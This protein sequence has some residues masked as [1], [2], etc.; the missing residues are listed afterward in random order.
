MTVQTG[1]LAPQGPQFEI[2]DLV[3]GLAILDH[4]S[5]EVSLCCAQGM[6]M[7]DLH[8][9]MERPC[10]K[11]PGLQSTCAWVKGTLITKAL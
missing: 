7:V 6:A 9:W 3:L 4:H 5:F 10:R 8:F 11:Q 2:D 1:G